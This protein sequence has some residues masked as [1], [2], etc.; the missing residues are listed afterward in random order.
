MDNPRRDELGNYIFLPQT[1]F[2]PEPWARVLRRDPCSYCDGAGGTV[3]HIVPLAHGGEK[4]VSVNGTGAC[5]TCN[6]LSHQ[7]SDTPLLQF[8]LKRAQRRDAYEHYVRS[9]P[10]ITHRFFTEEQLELLR[11]VAES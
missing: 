11:R 1:R 4:A 5:S 10:Q 7:K 6:S 3:D 8:L 9:S 2:D